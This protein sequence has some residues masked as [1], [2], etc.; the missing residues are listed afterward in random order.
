MQSRWTPE[1]WLFP[2]GTVEPNE[3]PKQAAVRETCEEAGVIGICGP[4]L[5]VWR[6]TKGEDQKIKLWLLFVTQQYSA[7]DKH[8]KERAKRSREWHSFPSAHHKMASLDPSLARPE[9]ADV[10]E[11]AR[12]VLDDIT[13]NGANWKMDLESVTRRAG[14][15][16][17]EPGRSSFNHSDDSD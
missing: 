9:L 16:I 17:S 5:G 6:T 2:K 10:L 15:G 8:W 11:T 14:N 12:L 7:T 4:K 1:V 3:S 13:G